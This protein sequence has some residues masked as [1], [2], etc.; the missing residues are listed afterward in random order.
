MRL[1]SSFEVDAESVVFHSITDVCLVECPNGSTCFF[2]YN[3]NAF[4][5]NAIM[6]AVQQK[7]EEQGEGVSEW[8]IAH[9]PSTTARQIV[10]MST[11]SIDDE[12][13]PSTFAG[14]SDSVTSG[15]MGTQE[16]STIAADQYDVTTSERPGGILPVDSADEEIIVV[17]SF[18]N[19]G[20]ENDSPGDENDGV[21]SM[22]PESVTIETS[23][24]SLTSTAS[25]ANTASQTERS[26]SSEIPVQSTE[27][28]VPVDKTPES[29]STT[30]QSFVSH[31]SAG[32]GSEAR[33]AETQNTMEADESNV[34]SSTIVDFVTELPFE[35]TTHLSDDI[36][37]VVSAVAGFVPVETEGPEATE[38][39][40]SI[41]E[42]T[43]EAQ[44]TIIS[45]DEPASS[46]SAADIGSSKEILANLEPT[47]I[48]KVPGTDLT[49]GAEPGFI[50]TKPSVENEQTAQPESEVVI[51]TTAIPDI[52]LELLENVTNGSAYSING[53]A[54][55]E[56]VTEAQQHSDITTRLS[57]VLSTTLHSI[58]ESILRGGNLTDDRVMEFQDA[59]SN[60][61]SEISTSTAAATTE[62]STTT[63]EGSSV[64]FKIPITKDPAEVEQKLQELVANVTKRFKATTQTYD[65][66]AGESTELPIS[67]FNDGV[68]NLVPGF[69]STLATTDAPET[70][71]LNGNENEPKAAVPRNL[72]LNESDLLHNALVTEG[73]NPLAKEC[74]VKGMFSCGSGCIGREKR[75][76]LIVDCSDGS[77]E[78]NCGKFSLASEQRACK[79]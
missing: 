37:A 78:S 18:P 54:E 73:T 52:N 32:T 75:C 50:V 55:G 7:K 8:P 22:M 79:Y 36:A 45:G 40:R 66:I 10:P 9:V 30:E 13:L 6:T 31:D 59:L 70:A 71:S 15:E 65:D 47:P 26:S 25:V 33:R 21:T 16:A 44:V 14:V 46:E 5:C 77:D 48:M 74:Q 35:N 42:V 49:S 39:E 38:A 17:D 11:T 62:Q 2:D 51:A 12:I 43:T 64:D 27:T 76:D 72:H 23:M 60:T 61:F 63:E 34:E 56:A 3:V 1:S 19:T 57:E 53:E 28:F 29:E 41:A 4:S 68:T 20:N 69:V 58:T 67:N 24:A